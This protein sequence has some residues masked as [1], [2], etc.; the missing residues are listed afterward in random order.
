MI[1]LVAALTGDWERGGQT[2]GALEAF[3]VLYPY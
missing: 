1:Q 2:E 3:K